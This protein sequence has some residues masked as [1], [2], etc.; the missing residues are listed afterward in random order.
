M[1]HPMVL[2]DSVERDVKVEV[3]HY[4]LCVTARYEA[5][6]QF[7]VDACHAVLDDVARRTQEDVSCREVYCLIL[8]IDYGIAR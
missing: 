3:A 6:L 2:S 7:E 1:R 5:S 4:L 8:D